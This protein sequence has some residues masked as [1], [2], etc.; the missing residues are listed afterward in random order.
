LTLLQQIGITPDQVI[1]ANIDETPYKNEPVNEYVDR[2][3]KEKAL[4]VATQN[5]LSSHFI[6]S[7]DTVVEHHGRILQKAESIHDVTTFLR[8]LSGRRHR[9]ITT[10]V[11]HHLAT[12]RTSIRAVTTS[13][14]FKRLS[15]AEIQDYANSGE[16][17][18]KAGGYAIQGLAATFV[19]DINGS[20]SGVVGLPLYETSQ[21]L[22][23][24]GYC[25]GQ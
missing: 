20:Y 13:V 11:L 9:V 8:C 21:L 23:G 12:N 6:L 22:K 7:A 4:H 24:M 3:A 17:I 1:A 18:G 15:Q 25:Y 2:I 16:G 5:N 10:V 19:T 14:R